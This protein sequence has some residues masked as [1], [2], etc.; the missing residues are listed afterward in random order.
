MVFFVFLL[1]FFFFLF[2]RKL[3]GTRGVLRNGHTGSTFCVVCALLYV[4][5]A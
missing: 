3:G 4:W 1:V 2:A 5:Y